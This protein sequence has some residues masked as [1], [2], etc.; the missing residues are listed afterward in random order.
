LSEWSALQ[1]V[2]AEE[3]EDK[4][5]VVIDHGAAPDDEDIEDEV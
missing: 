1:K 4:K 5:D 2:E 3:A